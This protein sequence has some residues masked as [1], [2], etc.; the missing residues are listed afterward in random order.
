[1]TETQQTTCPLC[2][3]PFQEG[4]V[5]IS[6]RI[7]P[8]AEQLGHVDCIMEAIALDEDDDDE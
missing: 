8:D 4:Q 1:M 2:D 6:F 5:V 3:E 7:W